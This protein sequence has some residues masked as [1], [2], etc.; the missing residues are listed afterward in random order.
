MRRQF[1]VS[2]FLFNRPIQGNQVPIPHNPALG[3]ASARYV[4]ADVSYGL[5]SSDCCDSLNWLYGLCYLDCFDSPRHST[6]LAY[7]FSQT[8]SS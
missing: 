1:P 4:F 7:G 3:N 2:A 6:A 8:F 5:D